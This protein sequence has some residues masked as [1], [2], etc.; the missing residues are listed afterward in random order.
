MLA[1][2]PLAERDNVILIDPLDCDEQLAA[3]PK[4]SFCVA[5]KTEDLGINNALH[6]IKH[7]NLPAAIIYFNGDPF[8][9]KVAKATK[10]T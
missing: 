2:S 1:I 9:D 10:D 6:A 3:L 4:N 5:K 8:P 7:K